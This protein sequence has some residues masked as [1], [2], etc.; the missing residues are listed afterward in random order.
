MQ[1]DRVALVFDQWRSW[2]SD[3]LA[4]KASQAAAAAAEE[5]RLQGLMKKVSLRMMHGLMSVAL[6]AWMQRVDE[7][8][9]S[10]LVISRVFARMQQSVAVRCFSSSAF[11]HIRPCFDDE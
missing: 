9:H 4:T 10:R 7:E 1:K 6:S 5:E 11:D 2:S 3:A 8:K